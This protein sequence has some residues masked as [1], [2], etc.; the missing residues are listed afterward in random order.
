M[1]R[2][3]RRELEVV[4]NMNLTSLLD[5]TFIL[6]VCFMMVAPNLNSG[7][8][9][10]LSKVEESATKP[11]VTNNKPVMI[12]IEN[13][14]NKEREP[15]VMIDGKLAADYKDLKK[16]LQERRAVNPK[17]DVIVGCDR[18]EQSEILLKVIAAIQAA[19]IESIGLETDVSPERSK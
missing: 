17:L 6:L 15:I 19:G 1:R 4:S 14:T 7:L 12:S 3:K 18:R 9:L 10:E 5:V 16:Q 2:H 8:Q 13:R 11:L